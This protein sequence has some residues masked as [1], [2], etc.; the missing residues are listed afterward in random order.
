MNCQC[1]NLPDVFYIE[2]APTG[3]EN[4]LIKKENGGWVWLGVCPQCSTLWK[5]DAW[6]KYQQQFVERVQNEDNW[7]KQDTTQQRK[8]LLLKSRG[9]LTEEECIWK[10]CHHKRVKDV[11]YCIDHL[12]DTGARK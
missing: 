3:F 5:I 4:N 1:Q 9:G 11:A 12:W 10:G 2:D 8:Q 6:D 7:E